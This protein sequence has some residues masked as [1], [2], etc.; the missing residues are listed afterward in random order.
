MQRINDMSRAECRELAIKNAAARYE[1]YASAAYLKSLENDLFYKDELTAAVIYGRWLEKE[2]IGVTAERLRLMFDYPLAHKLLFQM[3]RGDGGES[4]E[5]I[6]AK[7]RWENKSLRGTPYNVCFSSDSVSLEARLMMMAVF[8]HTEVKLGMLHWPLNW[9]VRDKYV[10]LYYEIWA[11]IREG[12]IMYE[13]EL[14]GIEK[15]E[16]AALAAVPE[17]EAVVL[18]P[19]E[20][21]SLGVFSRDG[22]IWVSSRDVAAKF[23]KNHRDVIRS[24]KNLDCS[25]E[26]TERNFALSEYKDPTGRTLPQYL[27]TRDGFTFLAMGFTGPKAARFKEAYIAEFNRMEEELYRRRFGGAAQKVEPV[28]IENDGPLPRASV[29]KAALTLLN[30]PALIGKENWDLI[31]TQT[32]FG[33]E[34]KRMARRASWMREN[35]ADVGFGSLMEMADNGDSKEAQKSVLKKYRRL[36]S[37]RRPLEPATFLPAL[38]PSS[39]QDDYNELVRKYEIERK[40]AATAIGNLRASRSNEE[41]LR[42]Q[43]NK[44]LDVIAKMAAKP[45]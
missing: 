33:C 11:G 23:E 6:M 19:E 9:N 36:G 21:G 20:T 8:A 29:M 5:M 17:P 31:D 4:S 35:D 1:E 25:E 45:E 34:V 3:F 13:T 38:P 16:S 7:V 39:L 24:V 30:I 2:G 27:M 32:P 37:S 28:R 43:L 42:H 18:T 12:R 41:K 44:A 14:L 40:K 15:R 10:Q 22:R 26:F